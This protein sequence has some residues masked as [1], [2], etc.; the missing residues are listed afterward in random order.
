MFEGDILQH[1]QREGQADEVSLLWA[2][3]LPLRSSQFLDHHSFN[4]INLS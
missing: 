1:P 2:Q 3:S 4:P